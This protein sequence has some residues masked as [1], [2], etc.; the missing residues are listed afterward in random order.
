MALTTAEREAIYTRNRSREDK[1]MTDAEEAR[2]EAE[3]RQQDD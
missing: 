1:A 2:R 3:Q